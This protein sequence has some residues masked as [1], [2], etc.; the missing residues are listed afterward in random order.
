MI[1][2]VTVVSSQSVFVVVVVGVLFVGG[3]GWGGGNG[4]GEGGG[5]LGS[6]GSCFSVELFRFVLF[7]FGRIYFGKCSH[8]VYFVH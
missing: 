1:S 6:Y 4:G 5:V 2:V 7:L 8:P 3:G